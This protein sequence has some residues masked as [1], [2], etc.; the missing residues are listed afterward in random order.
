MW[1]NQRLYSWRVSGDNI[2]MVKLVLEEN[3][4]EEEKFLFWT[5]LSFEKDSHKTENSI[6]SDFN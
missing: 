3:T 1:T 2:G 5:S 4:R 6:L